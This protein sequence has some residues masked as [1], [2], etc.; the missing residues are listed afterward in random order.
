MQTNFKK[1]REK[2]GKSQLE[3]AVDLDM[4]NSTYQQ[5]EAGL[6]EPNYDT[7]C[8]IAD[9]HQVSLDYLLGRTAVDTPPI[10]ID[11]ELAYQIN[12]LLEPEVKRS[13]LTLLKRFDK[14]DTPD[15]F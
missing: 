14:T 11:L 4:P 13:F 9:Y 1:L 15:Y 2:R 3:I 5:Y 6:R 7:L 8:R 10:E 12:R